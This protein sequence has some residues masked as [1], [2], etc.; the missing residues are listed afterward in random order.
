MNGFIDVE[1]YYEPGWEGNYYEPPEPEYIEIMKVLYKDIEVTDIVDTEKLSEILLEK[2]H[3]PSN[4]YDE[5]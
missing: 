5:D 2:I 3:S 4:Y 1:Y